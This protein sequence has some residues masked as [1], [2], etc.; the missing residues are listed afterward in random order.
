[1]GIDEVSKTKHDNGIGS[2]CMEDL[3]HLQPWN[4]DA[5]F[6][7]LICLDSCKGQLTGNLDISQKQNNRKHGFRA[8]GDRGDEGGL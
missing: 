5:C 6:Q 7:R 1:M 4:L 8:L 2:V 3:R